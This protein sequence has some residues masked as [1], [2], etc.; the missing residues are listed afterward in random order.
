MPS[1]GVGTGVKLSEAL[2]EGGAGAGG[3]APTFPEGS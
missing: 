3:G 1:E 2:R